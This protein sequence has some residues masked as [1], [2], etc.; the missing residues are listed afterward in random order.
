MPEDQEMDELRKLLDSLDPETK[1]AVFD[2][3]LKSVKQAANFIVTLESEAIR[4]AHA[5]VHSAEEAY[6]NVMVHIQ[7]EDLNS[8][9]TGLNYI[10]RQMESAIGMVTI[11][12]LKRRVQD[13]EKA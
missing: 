6:L 1:T 3:A 2:S 12:I 5:G 10:K 8:T 9:L 11:E 4:Q 7:T 13:G